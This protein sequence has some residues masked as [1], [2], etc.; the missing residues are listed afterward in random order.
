MKFYE[1][2]D[3]GVWWWSRGWRWWRICFLGRCWTPHKRQLWRYLA[4]AYWQLWRRRRPFFLFRRLFCCCCC[5][6]FLLLLCCHFFFS[7]PLLSGGVSSR[8]VISNDDDGDRCGA[9]ALFRADLE[10]YRC[11]RPDNLTDHY[12]MAVARHNLPS[13]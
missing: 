13:L 10:A 4:V 2:E 1:K 9:V 6:I 12:L 8:C 11:S 5:C 3:N 7:R